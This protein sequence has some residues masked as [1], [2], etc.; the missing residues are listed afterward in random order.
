MTDRRSAQSAAARNSRAL[1]F[2]PGHVGGRVASAQ[3]VRRLGGT[4]RGPAVGVAAARPATSPSTVVESSGAA[5]FYGGDGSSV[6]MSIT[7]VAG[8]SVGAIIGCE[9]FTTLTPPAGWRVLAAGTTSGY[10]PIHWAAIALDMVA[11]GESLTFTAGDAT[12]GAPSLTS[13]YAAWR[14][15]GASGGRWT[16]K[17]GESY[18]G[19]DGY[20][21]PA[22]PAPEWAFWA[23]AGLTNRWYG[24]GQ[25]SLVTA[26]RDY[27]IP[28]DWG[29]AT[30]PVVMTA[31]GGWGDCTTQP[32]AL[33]YV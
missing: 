23:Q 19:D 4:L 18:T 25:Y 10:S 2:V 13:A 12:G 15:V 30:E 11:G 33:G 9:G 28:P 8:Q 24:G 21:I 14:I 32:Y 5:G 31:I 20:Y 1:Q 6:E 29:Y 22:A 17:V 27:G 3:P 26:F 7:L 16:A